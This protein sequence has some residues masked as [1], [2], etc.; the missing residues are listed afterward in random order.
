VP[1]G[2]VQFKVYAAVIL[3]VGPFCSPAFSGYEDRVIFPLASVTQVDYKWNSEQIRLV[4]VLTY[5]NSC[6]LPFKTQVRVYEGLRLIVLV[7][8]AT[9]QKGICAHVLVEKTILFEIDNLQVGEYRVLDAL[10][11]RFL[12]NLI[13]DEEFVSFIL[14]ASS[15]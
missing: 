3:L 14:P 8:V 1:E 15:I 10:E 6:Y 9:I 4:A 11:H 2:E 12:G 13:V 7:H 5:P